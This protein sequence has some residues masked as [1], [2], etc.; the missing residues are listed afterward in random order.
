MDTISECTKAYLRNSLGT[1]EENLI[2]SV[3]TQIKYME[4]KIA[5][6]QKQL[7]EE[8]DMEVFEE[9]RRKIDRLE[10]RR[11]LLANPVAKDEKIEEFNGYSYV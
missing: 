7:I 10:I 6:L 9:I 11:Y 1:K 2:N 5:F 3:H 8:N 4:R